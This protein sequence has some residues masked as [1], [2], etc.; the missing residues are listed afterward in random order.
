[1]GNE[2]SNRQEPLEPRDTGGTTSRD[3]ARELLER[4][5]DSDEP[6]SKADL[7]AQ[8]PADQREHLRTSL[9]A[10]DAVIRFQEELPPLSSDQMARA[11][12]RLS[13]LRRR[14]AVRSLWSA[15]QT[16]EARQ[17]VES[18][19]RRIESSTGTAF[20]R[21][22]AREM[23]RSLGIASG[24]IQL[25]RNSGASFAASPETD[26]PLAEKEQWIG[27][28]AEALLKAAD[29]LYTP[30]RREFPKL[31][32]YLGIVT[33]EVEVEDSRLEGCLVT[34]GKVDG[35]IVNT[36]IRYSPRRANTRAHEIGHYILHR[37]LAQTC[38]SDGE[39]NLHNFEGGIE[40]EANLFAAALLIP[41]T[42]LRRFYTPDMPPRLTQ[43]N[44]LMAACEVSA[45]A[46]MY[47]LVRATERPCVLVVF[48]DGFVD[49]HLS[50]DTFEGRIL[51]KGAPLPPNSLAKQFSLIPGDSQNRHHLNG[52]PAEWW[53]QRGDY[54]TTDESTFKVNRRY[55][56]TLLTF[57]E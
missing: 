27:D 36:A 3:I 44:S 43:I 57:H 12:R 34:D 8:C 21:D 38:F 30:V 53:L 7:L 29:A 16:P 33:K 52:S 45:L 4:F 40:R 5:F 10:L 51:P 55:T 48:K 54:A 47:R 13:W 20:S 23:A 14:Q 6:I 35:I 17:R 46:A 22:P 37:S 25:N 31:E 56:Y 28:E 15:P 50:S 24:V 49:W 26:E 42:I 39:T 41:P 11:E 18:A 2:M 32:K 9:A 19:C 1:M